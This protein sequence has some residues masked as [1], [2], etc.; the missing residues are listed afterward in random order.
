MYIGN[1]VLKLMTRN[2]LLLCTIAFITSCASQ[3]NNVHRVQLDDNITY[4]LQ[5][6]PDVLI[7]T[8]I[9]ASVTVKRLG[10]EHQHLIQV[11]MSPSRIL[12]SGMTIE[13]V[14][15]FSLDWHT[16][17]EQLNIDKKITTDPQRILAEL[18]LALWPTSSIYQ[19]LEQG[20]LNVKE[21][22]RELTALG[23]VI[24]QIN[25]KEKH[26][27]LINLKQNYSIAVQELERWVL[28]TEQGKLEN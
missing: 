20:Q 16:E 8:G 19:G 2:I 12:I 17:L 14:S 9:L 26:S 1:N 23:E 7:N 25:T 21:N 6:V 15:L 18:Q 22:N 3:Q 28:T 4:V 24:Y 5:P 13:G 27:Q 11:E 10:E